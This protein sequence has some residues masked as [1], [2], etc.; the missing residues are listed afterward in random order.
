MIENIKMEKDNENT[1]SP[2]EKLNKI[3]DDLTYFDLYSSNLIGFIFLTIIVVLAYTYGI[4]MINSEEIKSDWINQRCKLQVM[5]FAGFINKPEGETILKYTGNNFTYCIQNILGTTTGYATQPLN[6]V[7][8]AITSIF[9]EISD[10]IN[11]IRNM[12]SN[13]RDSIESIARNIMNRLMNVMIPLQG[14]MISLT[15]SLNKVQGVLTL[16]L[17]SALGSYLTLQTL[18]GA[19]ADL[20]VKILIAIAIIIV[21]LW[22][23]LFTWPIAAATTLIFLAIAIPLTIIVVIMTTVMKIHVDAKPSCLD[24]NTFIVMNN[25]TTKSIKNIKVGD[26]LENNNVVKAFLKLSSKNQQMYN[27]YGTIVSGY[28]SVYYNKQWVKVRDCPLSF[29][30]TENYDKKEKNIYCLNTEKKIIPVKLMNQSLST[31]LFCDWDEMIHTEQ[32]EYL[33]NKKIEFKENI[34]EYLDV[35]FKYNTLFSLKNGK[36]KTIINLKPN[37][38]L[39]TGEMIVGVVTIIKNDNTI[40]YNIITDNSTF[41]ISHSHGVKYYDYNYCIDKYFVDLV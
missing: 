14:M 7:T 4:T 2:F 34:N 29:K 3:Y 12:I 8:S 36:T 27:L 6:Y 13:I 35:G 25:G 39:E 31:L 21:V 32:V 17:M 10:S 38:I 19:I 18:M 16:S 26:I 23:G 28:H 1:K 5:P 15:D 24:K 33:L 20:I 11:A 22:L 40:L 9:S 30:I 41:S 37:D